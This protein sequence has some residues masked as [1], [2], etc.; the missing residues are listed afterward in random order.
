VKGSHGLLLGVA[1][2]PTPSQVAAGVSVDA[3]A[4]MAAL[5]LVCCG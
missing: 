1:Q 5:Q 4:Q 2:F 3:L